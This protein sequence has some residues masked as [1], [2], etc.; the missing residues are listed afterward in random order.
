[1][2]EDYTQN[3]TYGSLQPS[4]YEFLKLIYWM[5]DAQ[6]DATS[7]K[8]SPYSLPVKALLSACL[9]IEGYVNVIGCRLDPDWEDLDEEDTSIQERVARIFK[10]IEQPISF[11]KG[12]WKDVCDLFILRAELIRTGLMKLHGLQEEE[13][14]AVFREV[15]E[16]YPI[17]LTQAI[18]EETIEQLLDISEFS[19][20]SYLQANLK[21]N[22]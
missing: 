17:R 1:M 22:L 21:H 9:A 20:A 8:R 12:V 11:D 4:G 10:K 3:L 6:T 5:K 7:A 19:N 15:A 14:P 18:A 2:L 16:E 13:Y